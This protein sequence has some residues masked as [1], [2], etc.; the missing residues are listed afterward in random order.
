M[1]NV[2]LIIIG[3]AAVLFIIGRLRRDSRGGHSCC[4]GS[5]SCTGCGGTACGGNAKQ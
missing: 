5:K 3:A 1:E 2:I 4:S